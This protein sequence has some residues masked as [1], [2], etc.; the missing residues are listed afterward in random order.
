MDGI[1]IAF[2]TDS[3]LPAV[4]GVVTSILNFREELKRRGHRVFVFASAKRNYLRKYSSNDTFLYPGI[5]FKPYPQYNVAIFPYNSVFK[6]GELDVDI[7]H[8][9]TPMV[10][11]F[12]GLIGAKV[13]KCRTVGTYHTNVTNRPVVNAYYPK[14]RHMSRLAASYM[15]KYMR[16]FY[17]SCDRVI[18]P[19]ETIKRMLIRNGI[20]NV[21]VVP[22]CIDISRFN[23]QVSGDSIREALGIRP[24][25]KMVLYLG[26]ISK[27]KR[28]EILLKAASLLMRK[29]ERVRLVIGGTGP[30]TEHYRAIASKLGISHK[31]KFIGFVKE[32]SLPELY[33]ACDAFCLPSTF[34]TQGIVVIEAMAMGKP[35]VGADY[36]AI[37]ELIKPGVNGE[38]F[39]SGDYTGCAKKIDK[40]LNNAGRYRHA[41]IRTAAEFSREKATDRLLDTYNR[42]L[43]NKAIN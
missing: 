34:E 1:R 2:F 30:A 32:K 5:E 19:S 9:Q 31:T 24:S 25:E 12:A 43:S 35:V 13:L 3:Y 7:V 29:D 39:R 4:D 28:I 14:N 40:V 6:L 26:R 38:K 11:G 33:A 41:A 15:T 36:M 21:G 22:N 27:E 10:M 42:V 20:E 17:N 18:S 23:A 8:S 37:K 16:F